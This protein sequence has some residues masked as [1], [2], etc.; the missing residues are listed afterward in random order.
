MYWEL[1]CSFS[2][3]SCL[4]IK[5][6]AIPCLNLLGAAISQSNLV[7]RDSSS[8]AALLFPAG[9]APATQSA[10]L[11]LRVNGKMLEESHSQK[12]NSS[13]QRLTQKCLAFIMILKVSQLRWFCA[14]VW[15]KSHLSSHSL[16]VIDQRVFQNCYHCFNSERRGQCALHT[17]DYRMW[18]LWALHSFKHDVIA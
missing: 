13:S 16:E 17:V 1:S 14:S 18:Q 3:G 7:W 5:S 4:L 2:L 12:T 8:D 15:V 10:L 6:A 11:S 9:T